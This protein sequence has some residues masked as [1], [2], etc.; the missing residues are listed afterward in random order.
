MA[1]S[2]RGAATPKGHRSR[3]EDALTRKAVQHHDFI[4]ETAKERERSRAVEQERMERDRVDIEKDVVR[5]MEQEFEEAAAVGQDNRLAEVLNFPRP[6]SLRQG[7]EILRDRGPAA[8]AI[9]REKAEE[10]LAGMPAPVKG[11]VKA[12]ERAF[13]ML[14]A[15]VRVGVHLIADALR[16]PAQ[17][18][19]LL[20]VNRRTA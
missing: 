11:A 16:T 2:K 5:E 3:A 8:F 4:G 20:L 12:S 9:L 1:K 14:A 17:M 10:R 19:R 13:G 15:P 7:I 6:K 18:L